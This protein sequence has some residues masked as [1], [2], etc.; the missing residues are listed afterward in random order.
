MSKKSFFKLSAWAL[1]AVFVSVSVTSCTI[2]DNAIIPSGEIE[3]VGNVS[4]LAGTWVLQFDAIGVSGV[5]ITADGKAY[6][7]EWSVGEAPDFSNVTV[8]ATV[9]VTGSTIKITHSQ[10]PGYFEEYSY[11]LSAD[12]TQLTFTLLDWSEDTHNL[13]GTYTKL[14]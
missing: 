14:Q 5:R 1:T 13:N 2:E 12:G 8:P 9:T 6:Y 10:M 11:V 7:N 3:V 4:A